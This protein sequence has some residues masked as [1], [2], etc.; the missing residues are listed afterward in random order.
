M[1]FIAPGGFGFFAA[2]HASYAAHDAPQ[3]QLAAFI[4]QKKLS[5]LAAAVIPALEQG[6][7]LIQFHRRGCRRIGNLR[8][9]FGDA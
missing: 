2:Q 4:G 7:M 5:R 3:R 9:A 1:R 6:D 8:Q